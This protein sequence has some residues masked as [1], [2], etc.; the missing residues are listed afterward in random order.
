VPRFAD[1]FV[2]EV[3]RKRSEVLKVIGG[4]ETLAGRYADLLRKVWVA[5]IAA[6]KHFER[7]YAV[8]SG[9][10]EIEVS[11]GGVLLVTRAMALE[12]GGR[13]VRK[14]RL[15]ALFP[16]D[17]RDY[18]DFKRLVREHVEHLV[19]LEALEEGA[20]LLLIDGSLYGRMIH[21]IRELEVEGREDFMLEYVEAYSKLLSRA[22]ENGAVVAGV[23][24]DSRSTVLKEELLLA[25]LASL[26]S[27]C[28]PE[29][30]GKVIE[31]WR[32]LRRRPSQALNGVRALVK[33]GLDP[34]VLELFE[35]ARS[36]VPDSKII[37]AA[38]LGAGFTSPLVLTLE[39]VSTGITDL[40]LRS[41]D[42]ELEGELARAF[43]RAAERLDFGAR[44]KSLLKALRSYPPV[45]TTYAVFAAGDDP[46]RV[47]V[48]ARELSRL[49]GG[50]RF[51]NPVPGI[52]QTV[53]A[54]LA[55]LYGGRR[56]YNA[57]LLEVDKRVRTTLE[58]LELYHKLAMR[59]V[60]ELILHSRGERRVLYP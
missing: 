9:S 26:L 30:K 8:D 38:G 4:G 57:L 20:D 21:V 45:Y 59:E 7:V 35:E 60:G 22:L 24:K 36:A 40:L 33:E 51:A 34:R 47:D 16:R 1:L 14:L 5:G 11:G 25:Q 55:L 29:L 54:H 56:C 41:R 44:V 17:L 53:L 18:E 42:E 6:G 52:V 28:E 39:R 48:V 12:A 3:R 31:L 23:S 43:E 27:G 19:A 49:A 2:E 13:E 46:V 15:D 50:S 37:S 10:D 32:L 58:T